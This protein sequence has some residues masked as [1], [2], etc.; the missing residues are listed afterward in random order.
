MVGVYSSVYKSLKPN[1]WG[2]K[3]WQQTTTL[4]SLHS[5]NGSAYLQPATK[6]DNS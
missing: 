4:Q 1:Y 3:I 6:N 2:K 5:L